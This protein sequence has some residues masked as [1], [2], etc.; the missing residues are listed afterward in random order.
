L[1]LVLMTAAFVAIY[2]PRHPQPVIV[3]VED[4]S[5]ALPPS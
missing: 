1:L 3:I 5:T 2:R 4:N